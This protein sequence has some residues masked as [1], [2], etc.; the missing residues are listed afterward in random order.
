MPAATD[1]RHAIGAALRAAADPDRAP[2]QQ[3][4]MKSQ[5]PFL[6]VVV[7][8]CRRIAAAAFR[9]HPLPD[10][11]SWEAAILGLWRQAAFREER[12]AAVEL[13]NQP[14]CS[15]WIEPRRVPMIEELVVTGAWWDYVDAIAGRAMG[16]MLVGHPQPTKS[17]L[18]GWARS[19]NVWKRRTAIL[20]QLRSKQ[21]TDRK[22]LTDVI[23]PSIDEQEL[24]LRKGIGWA[25][26][27]FSKT[28]PEWVLEF[29]DAHGS[30]SVLSRRE[31]LKHVERGR[32]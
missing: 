8:Q 28:D 27:E 15:R 30:L 25:L 3:A 24:F 32:R 26:R 14:R 13:L 20:A 7:P 23:E 22:L 19:D 16:T 9:A 11:D 12:Y 17:L 10:A 29:V 21:A 2:Q 1:I 6:G 4:Y 31:A 18:R 5:M